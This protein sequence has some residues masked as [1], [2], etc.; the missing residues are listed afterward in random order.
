MG[1]LLRPVLHEVGKDTLG[2]VLGEGSRDLF[3]VSRVV[4][5]ST[6]LLLQSVLEEL[7]EVLGH[8]WLGGGGPS[9][10]GGGGGGHRTARRKALP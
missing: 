8:L 9:G 10:G 5:C 2:V 1:S 3:D 7:G 4:N 6:H